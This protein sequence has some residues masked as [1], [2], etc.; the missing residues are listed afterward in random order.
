MTD[1]KNALK[2]GRWRFRPKWKKCGETDLGWKKDGGRRR[3]Y[4]FHFFPAS[5][6]KWLTKC[7]LLPPTHPVPGH[8]ER[9]SNFDHRSPL[10]WCEGGE[11][12]WEEG[13]DSGDE[14]W[15]RSLQ[16]RSE[17]NRSRYWERERRGGDQAL[18]PGGITSAS[19]HP[20]HPTEPSGGR[21]VS[22]SAAGRRS[23]V[24]AAQLYSLFPS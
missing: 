5:S 16:I 20:S 13:R 4:S 12:R 23:Q 6:N 8:S 2:S 3:E 7:S 14:E 10:K 15:S 19:R 9:P 21:C 1:K 22:S 17:V 18:E 11:Q 24:L